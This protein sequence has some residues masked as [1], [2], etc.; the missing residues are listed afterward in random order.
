[1]DI[2]ANTDPALILLVDDEE[3]ILS[4]YNAKLQKAGFRTVTATNGAEAIQIAVDQHPDL[5]LM[6]MKMPVMDGV[7]ALMKLKENPATKDIKVVFLTAFSDPNNPEIDRGKA[8]EV[9][10]LDFIKKGLSL[11]E[12]V[13]RVRGYLS[14]K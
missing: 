8:K 7:E 11:D 13:E 6:D 1:M 12:L 3:D 14:K 4:V 5:I 9:G 2:D 10:A